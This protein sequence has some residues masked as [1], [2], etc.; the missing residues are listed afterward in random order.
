MRHIKVYV[1]VPQKDTIIINNNAPSY[2]Y[3]MWGFLGLCMLFIVVYW[4]KK[5][6]TTINNPTQSIPA[7]GAFNS[8]TLYNSEHTVHEDQNVDYHNIVIPDVNSETIKNEKLS[9][10]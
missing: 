9:Y 5:N 2:H 3:E 10:E 4:F 1:S 6:N 8:S 7:W